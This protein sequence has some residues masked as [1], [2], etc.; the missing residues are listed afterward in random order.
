MPMVYIYSIVM[1]V[2]STTESCKT[3]LRIGVFLY[4]INTILFYRIV[5]AKAV[6]FTSPDDGVSKWLA[7]VSSKTIIFFVTKNH[8]FL[9][10]C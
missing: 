8:H 7:S 6:V 3:K 5:L 2:A 1:P 9:F 4:A 10:Q